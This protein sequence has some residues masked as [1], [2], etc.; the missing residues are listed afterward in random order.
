MDSGGHSLYHVSDLMTWLRWLA[1]PLRLPTFLVRG[2][3]RQLV[4]VVRANI[5]GRI[6]VSWRVLGK[7][8]NFWYWHGNLLTSCQQRTWLL[9]SWCSTQGKGSLHNKC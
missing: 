1:K 7:H 3:R 6:Q 5:E 2:W 4:D 9:T 8:F